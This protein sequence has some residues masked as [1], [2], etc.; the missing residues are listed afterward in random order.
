MSNPTSGF[1]EKMTAKRKSKPRAIFPSLLHTF[2]GRQKELEILNQELL[3]QSAKIVCITGHPGVGKTTLAMFF[4]KKHSVAFPGGVYNLHATPFE[5]LDQTVERDIPIPSQAY[6]V[7]I[8]N[9]EVRPPEHLSA[10]I[11]SLRQKQPLARVILTSRALTESVMID[12]HLN[13]SG[14]S[15]SE[16]EQL[17]RRQMVISQAIDFSAQLCIA[18]NGLPLGAAIIADLFKHKV[19][20]PREVLERLSPFSCPG[21]VDT[22]GRSL[23]EDTPQHKQIVTDIVSVS[24]DFL[25]KLNRDPKLLYEIP[26]RRFEEL[27]AEL[28]SRLKYE[29]TLTPASHD[30]G[31]DIYAAR[32]DHLGTFLYIVECKKYAPDHPVG[33][34]LVR[35][36]NGVVHAEQATA[37]I[38][39][40][41]S[42]FT[43]GAQQFQKTVAFQISLK[44]YF[45]IQEWL[46]TVLKK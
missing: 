12:L 38:L 11:G 10:E 1:G 33:V 40:T 37:G 6:L 2:V 14:L 45:G 9:V 29:I 7:I 3:G 4:A 17:V 35:Q 13:L 5:T 15:E 23:G 25:R 32:K 16:F 39:A 28:L 22:L 18:F 27:V 44:D 19:L 42:F 20:T 34:A 8:N 41:T 46:N 24:D 30:G 21:V 26:S 43:S 31:K 36:L